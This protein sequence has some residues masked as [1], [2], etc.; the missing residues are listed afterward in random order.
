MKKLIS[1]ILL[2]PFLVSC[3]SV[4]FAGR[5]EDILEESVSAGE[6]ELP[7][8]KQLI[9][10]LEKPDSLTD[11]VWGGEWIR[12]VLVT[13]WVDILI[14]VLIFAWIILAIIGFYK[15]MVSESA[16]ETSKS[17]NYIVYW[18]LGT[19]IMV[20]AWYITSLLIGSDGSGWSVF[21]FSS[22][23][24][25]D[26]PAMAVDL[27]QNLMYP[28]VKLFLALVLGILFI[29]VLVSALRMIFGNS[30]DEQKN[31]INMFI[32]GIVWVLV[33]SL[34]RTIVEL[35]YGSYDQVTG[36]IS[37]NLGSIWLLFDGIWE[38]GEAFKVIRSI[39]NRVLW[40]A[41][42]IVVVIIIYLWFMMLFRPDDEEAPKR[43]K[44][45]LIYA[46]VGIFVI[47]ASYILS[48]MLIVTG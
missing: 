34:S 39:L 13:I 40:L 25:F 48:R 18:L 12:N 15:L 7:E 22:L 5:Y 29:I 16:E 17:Y 21:N 14:P 37:D 2:V 35:V 28:F 46:L 38:G 24:E 6:N 43:V 4:S 36:E 31:A 32:Y 3:F 45:Y 11:G 30:E 47:W 33:I 19:I 1:L 26:G 44:K 20:S 41:V 23:E 8:G 9:D 27:Y 10:F 42:F